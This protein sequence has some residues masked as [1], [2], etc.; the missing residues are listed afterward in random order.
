MLTIK[1]TCSNKIITR[2]LTV[3]NAPFIAILLPGAD[4]C[5]VADENHPIPMLL[6]QNPGSFVIYNQHPL[7][8]AELDKLDLD[9]EQIV[10]E[11]R[12]ETR[13]VLGLQA[14]YHRD[15][16]GQFIELVYQEYS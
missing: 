2:V 14:R 16:P 5:V 3:G 12:Q 13:G 11:V 9:D 4:D 15:N 6:K 7:A 1:R 10:I 8:Q